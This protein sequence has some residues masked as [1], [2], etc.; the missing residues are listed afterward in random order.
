ML[1]VIHVAVEV[2]LEHEVVLARL[3][4][5]HRREQLHR[6][7]LVPIG[8]DPFLGAME[9]L[10]DIRDVWHRCRYCDVPNL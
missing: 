8:L 9:P 10:P 7:H 4:A 6:P 2:L 5:Q 3:V 1:T